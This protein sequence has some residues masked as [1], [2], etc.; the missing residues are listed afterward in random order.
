MMGRH[1]RPPRRADNAVVI[2]SRR[3]ANFGA[4]ASTTIL[5]LVDLPNVR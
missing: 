3:A 1:Q 2:F 4:I 5:S